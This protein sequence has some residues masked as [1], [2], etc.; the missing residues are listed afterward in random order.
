MTTY[1]R[2]SCS[3]GLPR[4]PF[5]NCRQFMYL[6]ISLLVLRAGYGIWLYQFLI[7]AYLFTLHRLMVEIE[8]ENVS[9][10]LTKNSSTPLSTSH[11]NGKVDSQSHP[12]NSNSSKRQD[13]NKERRDNNRLPKIKTAVTLFIVK[14][15]FIIAFLSA[16][17]M[18]LKVVDFKVVIFYMYFVYNVANPI[19]YAFMN[20]MF[21][22]NLAKLF[23]SWR[24]CWHH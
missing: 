5:V 11:Q 12:I 7:I 4:V 2:K 21:H 10:S 17:L 9:T 15:V 22:E 19:I 13:P 18:A 3:F 16:W 23:G 20:K 14:L 6:V 8:I 1:L 24:F